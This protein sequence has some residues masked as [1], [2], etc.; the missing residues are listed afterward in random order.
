VTVDIEAFAVP[1]HATDCSGS[2]TGV[3][4]SKYAAPM[5]AAGSSISWS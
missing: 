5:L 2:A 1:V 4:P 3:A